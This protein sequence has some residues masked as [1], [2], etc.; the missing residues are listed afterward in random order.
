MQPKPADK[1]K[2]TRSK[3]ADTHHVDPVTGIPMSASD[4]PT[5]EQDFEA[6]I[7]KMAEPLPQPKKKE[8]HKK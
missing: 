1:K 7:S 8:G 3:E 2:R 6:L 4:N 5:H